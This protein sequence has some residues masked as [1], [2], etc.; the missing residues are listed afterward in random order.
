MIAVAADDQARDQLMQEKLSLLIDNGRAADAAQLATTMLRR[1]PNSAD[2]LNN[3]CWSR[4]LANSELEGAVRDCDL[5][6]KA[7][8]DSAAIFDSR[9]W[10]KL[11]L[12]RLDQ[13]I[14]DFDSALRVSPRQGASLYGRGLAKLR[15]GDKEGGERD[16]A[17]ARRIDFDV[18]PLFKRYGLVP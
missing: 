5:A 11:R 13:A 6:L 8:P 4:A 14:A 9:A 16:L 7:S 3:R 12:G 17:E 18:E 2:N 15:K 1:Q 10:V